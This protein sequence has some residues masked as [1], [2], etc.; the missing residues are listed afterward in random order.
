MEEELYHQSSIEDPSDSEVDQLI[1]LLN[2]EDCP[3]LITI[4]K[5]PYTFL[6]QMEHYTPIELLCKKNKSRKLK[7][8]IEIELLKHEKKNESSKQDGLMNGTKALD[9][10]FRNYNQYEDLMDIVRLLLERTRIDFDR[11]GLG[12][13]RQIKSD[14]KSAL[15]LYETT[16]RD[17]QPV[18]EG[19]KGYD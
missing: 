6:K 12:L 1:Q 9:F 4:E 2:D 14:L 18:F 17:K 5:E 11:S 8:L 7:Q 3:H 19:D 10:I 15:Y 13:Q 16:W